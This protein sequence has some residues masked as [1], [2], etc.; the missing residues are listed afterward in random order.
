EGHPYQDR[1]DGVPPPDRR[2]HSS[3][4][5]IASAPV[6]PGGPEVPSRV[7]Y[8]DIAHGDQGDRCAGVGISG[9]TL[10]CP[11]EA[12]DYP[13]TPGARPRVTMISVS[14][15]ADQA[16]RAQP[17]ARPV[18]APPRLSRHRCDRVIAGVSS[19]IAEHLTI[20]VLWVR[21]IFVAL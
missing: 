2:R 5:S 13:D 11:R 7:L 21:V 18:P 12:R 19:G 1:V 15:P 20:P 17:H 8:A 14:T 4:L 9:S 10:I 6:R 3:D 16:R